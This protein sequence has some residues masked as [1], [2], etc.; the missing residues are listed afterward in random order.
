M[1]GQPQYTYTVFIS[2][3]HADRAWVWEEWTGFESLLIGTTD[4][5]GRKRRLLPLMLRPCQPVLQQTTN[6]FILLTLDFLLSQSSQL[7]FLRSMK[8]FSSTLLP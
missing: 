3:S 7:L 1:S 8:F 6:G 4:P 2:Y 5:A